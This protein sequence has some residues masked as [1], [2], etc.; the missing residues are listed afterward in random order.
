MKQ[1]NDQRWITRQTM[2]A[3]PRGRFVAAK[4]E[5]TQGAAAVFRVSELLIR[6]RTQTINALRG[7]LAEFGEVVPQRISNARRL[8]ALVEAEGAVLPKTMRAALSVLVTLLRQ[9]EERIC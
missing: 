3:S 7:H 1:R 2:L 9:L 6:Q 4:S 8:I 5:E